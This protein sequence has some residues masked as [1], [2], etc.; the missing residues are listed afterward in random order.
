[1]SAD[2]RVGPLAPGACHVVELQFLAL[3]EGVVGLEAKHFA[4]TS[5]G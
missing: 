1:L 3:Q 2:T 5:A 4:L